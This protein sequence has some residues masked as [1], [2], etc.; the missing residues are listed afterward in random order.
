MATKTGSPM[1]AAGASPA[2]KLFLSR[3]GDRI[4]DNH[5]CCEQNRDRSER[6]NGP[7]EQ[8]HDFFALIY[9]EV[10]ARPGQGAAAG[11]LK[12]KQ[13]GRCPNTNRYLPVGLT[14]SPLL[15]K[16]ATGWTEKLSSN[17]NNLANG[18][19]DESLS[20]GR[21]RH[22]PVNR[23]LRKRGQTPIVQATFG[24][25]RLLGSDPFFAAK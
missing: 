20:S 8:T 17:P 23:G 4:R 21:P 25:F 7:S 2:L 11:I 15:E 12:R 1:P 24:P 16:Q 6:S 22:C 3:C 5:D 18:Q 9:K 14:V 10:S 13:V 19:E